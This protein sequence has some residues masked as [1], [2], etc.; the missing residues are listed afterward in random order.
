[1]KNRR[2]VPLVNVVKHIHC[3]VPFIVHAPFLSK[4][5]TPGKSANNWASLFIT[6][7]VRGIGM[8]H[9]VRLE[10]K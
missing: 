5:V 10:L 2:F 6:V 9:H 4:V 8:G 1:M 7:Q 3:D